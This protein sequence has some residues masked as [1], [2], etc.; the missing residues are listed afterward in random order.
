MSV[1][2]WVPEYNIRES[3]RTGEVRVKQISLEINAQ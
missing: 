3:E 2:T 1:A